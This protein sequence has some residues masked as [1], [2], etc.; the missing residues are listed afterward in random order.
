VAGK[1]ESTLVDFV[2]KATMVKISIIYDHFQRFFDDCLIKG[3]VAKARAVSILIRFFEK[4]GDRV[5]ST[6]FSG[7]RHKPAKSE[8]PGSHTY[9]ITIVDESESFEL[10][11]FSSMSLMHLRS[12]LLDGLV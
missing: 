5:T 11:V 1:A 3:P 7:S 9:P 8:G 4:F 2:S 12:K 10:N 6:L